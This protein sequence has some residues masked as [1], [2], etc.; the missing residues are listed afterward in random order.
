MLIVMVQTLH[1]KQ[2]VKNGTKIPSSRHTTFLL[3]KL[4]QLRRHQKKR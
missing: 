4:D 2:N 3:Q 1:S